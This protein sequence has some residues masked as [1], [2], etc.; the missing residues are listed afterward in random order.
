[1]LH[2]LIA[3][4]FSFIVC[5]AVSAQDLCVING[6]ISDDSPIGRALLGSTEGDEVTVVGV[7]EQTLRVLNVTRAKEQH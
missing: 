1:M 3:T 2:R 7:R 6:K 5:F 4:I